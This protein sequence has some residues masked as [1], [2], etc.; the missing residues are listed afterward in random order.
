MGD[1][2]TTSSEANAKT[3]IIVEFT[4]GLEMLFD[5]INVHNLAVPAL[6]TAGSSFTVGDLIPW[7]VENA[8]KDSR[9][10]LFVLDSGM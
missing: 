7:L 3:N 6:N 4:G 1:M 2:A 9:K 10:E 5:N 8:M